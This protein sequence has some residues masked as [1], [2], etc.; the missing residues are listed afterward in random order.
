V[1]DGVEKGGPQRVDCV[2]KSD[3][4]QHFWVERKGWVLAKR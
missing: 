1:V 3:T 2:N 4:N